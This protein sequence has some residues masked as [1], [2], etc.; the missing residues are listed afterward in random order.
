VARKGRFRSLKSSDAFDKFVVDQLAELGDVMS[1]KMF[2][3]VGLYCDGVFFGIVARDAL[4]LKVDDTTR[5]DYE[6]A[7]SHAFKPYADRPST[8]QYYNVPLNVLE[9]APEL[10]TWA[11]RAVGVARRPRGPRGQV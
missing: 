1:K 7:G 3:G 2:G 9:S 10:V 6:T 5:A 11:R 8:M 4:Y